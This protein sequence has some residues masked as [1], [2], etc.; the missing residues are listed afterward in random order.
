MLF[1][2]NSSRSPFYLLVVIALAINLLANAYQPPKAISHFVTRQTAV[3]AKFAQSSSSSSSS[4]SYALF[5]QGR[6]GS[7]RAFVGSDAPSSSSSID[8]LR[9]MYKFSRPHTIKGTILASVM[10]VTRALMENPNKISLKLVPKAII[11]LFALLCGNAYI[12]GINQIYDV[13]IDEINKPFLPIAANLLSSK[14]A[15][16]IV[17]SCL[18]AGVSIVKTQ[19][20]RPIFALYMLGTTLG[21]IY[22]IPPFNFKRIP[23]LAGAIIATVRGF[24]LNFGVYYAVREA[25]NI[26]FQWNPVVG[27]ISSFMTVFATVIAI[28]KDLPDVEG[29]VKYNVKTLASTYGIKK[30]ATFCSA[31]LASTY[32]VAISLPFMVPHAGFKA[33]PMSLGHSLFLL[34][35]IKSFS[36]LNT[37]DMSSVKT[38]Y[39]AIWNLFYLEYCLYPFI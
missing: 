2:S 35:F 33:L 34:Y 1:N 12:V 15:W 4:S 21:T 37:T 8:P 3:S 27:F 22:S 17:L 19:F 20:S 26:P 9:V 5:S 7:D 18:V 16:I 38:F 32:A 31:L 29:D 13:K 30:V 25:L 10:A 39:K 28:T 11:G 6:Y 23:I 14:N 24:L 36:K